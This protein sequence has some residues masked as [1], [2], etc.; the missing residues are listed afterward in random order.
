M[1]RVKLEAITMSE[2]QRRLSQ[3][4]HD[5]IMAAM[6]GAAFPPRNSITVH[7]ASGEFI[8]HHENT[9]RQACLG[10]RQGEI[11]SIW[12]TEGI[13]IFYSPVSDET[14]H[15]DFHRINFTIE[16]ANPL[17]V[18]PTSEIDLQTILDWERKQ[19]SQP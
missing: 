3:R 10:R 18:S 9:I 11:V 1:A 14:T 17:V 2:L 12:I 4:L 19:G 6:F 13:F 5:D 8:F 16:Q 15:Q 7:N